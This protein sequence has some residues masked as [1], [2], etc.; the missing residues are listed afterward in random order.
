MQLTKI[1]A[2][3]FKGSSF[4]HELGRATL[5]VGD[6]YKGKSSITQAI[7]LALTGT[8][9]KPIGKVGGNIYSALAGNPDEA[10]KLSVALTT[11]TGREIEWMWTR[12]AKGTV[13][14]KGSVP[15][16][17]IVPDVVIDPDTFFALPAADRS[18]ALMRAVPGIK[19]DLDAWRA[20]MNKIQ[21]FPSTVRDVAIKAAATIAD[22]FFGSGATPV[23]ACERT[24]E[25]IA[26]QAKQAGDRVKHSEGAFAAVPPN[27][28]W[29]IDRALELKE[30]QEELNKLALI[31]A[32]FED[33]QRTAE[34]T[35]KRR[36]ALNEAKAK[37]QESIKILTAPQVETMRDLVE[38]QKTLQ[39]QFD[40]ALKDQAKLAQDVD[41]AKASRAEIQKRLRVFGHS[42]TGKCPLCDSSVEASKLLE[43]WQEESDLLLIKIEET[44]E[45]HATAR[46]KCEAA[47]KALRD[48][49]AQIVSRTRAEDQ[50]ESDEREL[51]NVED[52]LAALGDTVFGTLPPRFEESYAAAEAKVAALNANQ[53]RL[54]SH[55]ETK[56]W[57][58]KMES[59]LIAAR[60]RYD[61][62]KEA[63]KLLRAEMEKAV[64]E[65]FGKVLEVANQFTDGI[66]ASRLELRDGELGRRA[67]KKDVE[68]SGGKLKA[69][70]W[71]PHE[72]FSGT[73]RL[74][75]FAGFATAIAT[76]S[77]IKLVIMDE[78][79][80]VEPTLRVAVIKRMKALTEAGVIDQ[81]IGIDASHETKGTWRGLT[82]IEL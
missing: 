11:D 17:L 47:L 35:A 63:V 14:T 5:I 41:N 2:H 36:T 46:E 64:A 18:V 59:D 52:S 56:E 74:I 45:Q 16:D 57:R 65:G 39:E 38:Q 1:S 23:E 40:S 31:K 20:E 37:L 50:L 71:I 43:Q 28:E 30:A 79:G 69:G 77:P 58:D 24:V 22:S 81:F 51:K 3:N 61:T 80:R 34:Q 13:S 6:N 53:G 70:A 19:I 72:G 27:T 21:A 66:L 12:S 10:G 60:C 67:G 48:K 76:T 7:R 44:E 15:A 68:R 78:L 9:P 42:E 4:E 75:A 82:V 49:E 54:K 32:K 62:L 8:M 33:T 29:P 25:M 26:E 73:E 55:A